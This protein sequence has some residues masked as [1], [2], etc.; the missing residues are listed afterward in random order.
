MDIRAFFCRAGLGGMLIISL[1][2]PLHAENQLVIKGSILAK[3]CDVD[4]GS[5]KQTVDLGEH[6]A[7]D[8]Y[9][10][11]TT[12]PKAFTIKL[13]NCVNTANADRGDE[14]TGLGATVTF[15]GEAAQGDTTLLAL[16]G[17]TPL[18]T[19]IG[20]EV[21]TATEESIALGQPSSL[22][23]LQPGENDLTFKLRYKATQLPVHSGNASAVLYFDIAYQ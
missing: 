20:V 17:T 19:N 15:S 8:F 14:A 3:T 16:S 7:N 18:A 1:G 23:V 5:A 4:G 13:I 11:I 12:A 22:Y 2:L 21:L 10:Q 6:D 9:D